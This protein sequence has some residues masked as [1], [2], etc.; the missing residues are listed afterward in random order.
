[1][2]LGEVGNLKDFQLQCRVRPMRCSVS[3]IDA[4][5]QFVTVRAETHQT[6]EQAGYPNVEALVEPV[7]SLGKKRQL[8]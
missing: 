4:S 8:A 6:S 3:S 7:P 2:H 1:M 5:S